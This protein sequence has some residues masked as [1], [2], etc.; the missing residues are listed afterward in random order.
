MAYTVLAFSLV[1]Y[2]TR[3]AKVRARMIEHELDVL[4][5]H[6]PANMCWLTGYNSWSFYVPQCVVVTHYGEPLWFGR[7]MDAAGAKRTCYLE[8]HNITS[9]PDAYVMNPP[10]HPMDYLAQRVLMPR[11][12]HCGRI[13]VEKDNYYFSAAAYDALW[14]SLPKCELLD[15]TGLVN[16]CR[17]IKSP[18]E[19][20][21]LDHAARI[22]E[23][24][25]YI[26]FEL[27]DVGLPKH[28]LVAEIQRQATL[29]VDD[30]FGDY[31]SIVP[32]LPS[33]TESCAPHLTWDERAFRRGEGTCLEIAGVHRRYH[34]PLCRTIF[35]GEPPS[36]FLRA[37]DA[38]NRGLEA[39]IEVAKP[40]NTCA[41]IANALNAI[42]DKA[43]FSRRD[44]RCGYSVGLSYPPDW[45]EHTMSLRASDHTVLEPGMVFHFMP[46][47][48]RD[49]WG[50]ETTESIVITEHGAKPLCDYPR[51]LFVKK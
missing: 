3:L 51:H 50:L 35:L 12:W 33:G 20:I 44:T 5:V 30:H 36:F 29:G 18:Q 16:Q 9:Y 34:S 46:G 2:Q 8:P 42:L 22:V 38:L 40:G 43:G 27:I 7:E 26:A 14:H 21:Y 24:M 11:D 4:I 1:E 25:H 17:A 15:A 49:D 6:D 31:P 47:L 13:G 10:L 39:G 45:G 32:L 48:W 19:L 41:D 23:Q 37:D 28:H